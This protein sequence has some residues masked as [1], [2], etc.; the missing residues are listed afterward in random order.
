VVVLQRKLLSWPE[1]KLLRRNA[2]RLVFDFDD[3][4]WLRDSYSPKGFDSPKR[5]RRFLRTVAGSDA[6]VAGNRTLAFGAGAPQPGQRVVVIPTCVDAARYPLAE[7]AATD[8]AVRLVWLGSSS[9]LQGLERNREMLDA[10]GEAVPGIRLK[11]ICDRFPTFDKLP[12]D[13]VPWSGATEAAE[14]AAADIGI[15]WVPDDPWSRGKCGLKLLQYHAAGLA[16]VANPVG[17]QAEM[18]RP[19][20]T[21]IL[22][23][24]V[25]EWV[26]AVRS[27]AADPVL[28]LHFGW[29]G[30][31]QVESAFGVDAG[32]AAWVEL[33]KELR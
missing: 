9:T 23:R 5:R 22:A 16:V 33:L 3:A 27:L 21:G 18:V 31:R 11:V 28:R 30:R 4:L 1:F 12:V 25:Q 13:G 6:V 29:A 15:G 19:H 2:R 26:E 32:G 24:T 14:L 10:V 7:H 20:E 17:V 8:G